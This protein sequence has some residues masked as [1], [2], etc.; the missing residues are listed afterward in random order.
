ME[1]KATRGEWRLASPGCMVFVLAL[2]TLPGFAQETVTRSPGRGARVVLVSVR[3][4]KLAVTEGGTVLA[5]FPIAVGASSSP[6]PTGEFTI[7]TRVA[8]P[9][10]YHHGAVIPSGKDSPVGT[11]WLGL[12]KKGYG[13]HG[14]NAPRSIGHAASHGCIRLRN[15]DMERLFPLLEVGDQVQIH[16]E[17]DEAVAGV[18]PPS[19]DAAV[20]ADQNQSSLP[21][22]EATE[23]S[24]SPGVSN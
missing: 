19:L 4:R 7:V 17:R 10:Y 5:T 24:G 6:S 2:S 11:R 8:N 9:T 12:N 22:E 3:D 21:D 1:M 13:I 23:T 16:G 14:T 18:F 15:Q 20:L